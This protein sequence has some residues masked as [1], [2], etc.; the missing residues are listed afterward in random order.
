MAQNKLMFEVGVQMAQE[1]L[2]K[3]EKDFEGRIREITDK[4]KVEIN[5]E[6]RNLKA[7]TEGLNQMKQGSETV[8]DIRNGNFSVPEVKKITAHTQSTKDDA[9]AGNPVNDFDV[10]F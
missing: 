1:Q 9:F 10:P 4:A 8:D 2:N 6:I 3:L 7:M 5:V